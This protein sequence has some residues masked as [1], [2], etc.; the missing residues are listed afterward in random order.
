[1]VKPEWMGLDTAINFHKK[2]SR[3]KPRISWDWRANEDVAIKIVWRVNGESEWNRRKLMT[4]TQDFKTLK[5]D[6]ILNE[7]SPE[8]MLCL[9]S[10]K[11]RIWLH[12]IIPKRTLKNLLLFRNCKKKIWTSTIYYV[13]KKKN[14]FSNH[15]YYSNT[16]LWTNSNSSWTIFSSTIKTLLW[17]KWTKH[18]LTKKQNNYIHPALI[19][20]VDNFFRSNF[21]RTKNYCE[22]M[23][24]CLYS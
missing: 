2:S 21:K 11:K 3:I 9:N 6:V 24:E 1:M 18:S 22:R 23:L 5:N 10:R 4:S 7:T 20:I 17:M 12:I 13:H 16:L 8:F 14:S 19:T 15:Y